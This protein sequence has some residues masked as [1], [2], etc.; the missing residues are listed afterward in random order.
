MSPAVSQ[1]LWLTSFRLFHQRAEDQAYSGRSKAKAGW[2]W[3][4]WRETMVTSFWSPYVCV[5]VC[6]CSVTQPRVC[7]FSHSAVCVHV[8]VCVHSAVCVFTQPCVCVCTRMRVYIQ[9]LSRVCVCIFSHS[10]V[11]VCVC[12]FSHS[13]VCVCA[14][15]RACVYSVTQPCLKIYLALEQVPRTIHPTC[16]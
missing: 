2:L 8:C 4:R 1:P 11:C 6:V 14:C 12:V 13:A 3:T 15:T 10:A 5:R 7:V 9:S 16:L